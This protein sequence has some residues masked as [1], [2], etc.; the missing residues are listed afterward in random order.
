MTHFSI[1]VPRISREHSEESI[2]IHFKN[3]EISIVDYVDFVPIHKKPSF[4]EN[5]SYQS[6]FIHFDNPF[7]RPF[8]KNELAFWRAIY[9]DNGYKLQISSSKY[10]ICLKNTNPIQRTRKHIHRDVENVI[11]SAELLEA[12]ALTIQAQDARIKELE[13]KSFAFETTLYQLIAGLFDHKEQ[14]GIYKLHLDILDGTTPNHAFKDP[15]RWGI[16][17]TTLQGT[18]CERKIKDLEF[19]IS[20]IYSQMSLLA[21]YPNEP[22]AKT[23]LET[24]L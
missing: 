16:Y 23:C 17:P 13:S 14:S 15:S 21:A 8:L 6:A 22:F 1:Y 7:E 11:N 24:N 9:S 4:R 10:W 12:Q 18:E 20:E 3:L 5:H 19:K 2:K